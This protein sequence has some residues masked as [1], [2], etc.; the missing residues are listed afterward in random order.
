MPEAKLAREAELCYATLALATDYDCWHETEEAVTVE[1][2]LATL[3]QNVRW[4]SGCCE[5]VVPALVPGRTCR[6]SARR[7][8]CDCHRSG[9]HSRRASTKASAVDSI[10]SFPT[11]GNERSR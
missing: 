9:S 8:K 10:E 5:A 4:P 3:H 2:I 7:S 6:V 11:C 1:A